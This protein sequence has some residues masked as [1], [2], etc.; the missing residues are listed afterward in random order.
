M[1]NN[2]S[3]A[4]LKKAGLIM[5]G[6]VTSHNTLKHQITMFE[7]MHKASY[8]APVSVDR[9]GSFSFID[10]FAGIGG[11]RIALD[12]LNGNC[13]GFSEIDKEAVSTYI[14]NYK[15]DI[16]NNFGDIQK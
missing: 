10:L 5:G 11:F 6:I 15:D 14:S 16:S 9:D 1:S 4:T 8:T 2:Y 3:M 13:I 7:Y 12:K